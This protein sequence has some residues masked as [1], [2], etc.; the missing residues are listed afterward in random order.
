M[1]IIYL[2]QSKFP[3]ILSGFNL[4]E[5][6]NFVKGY[7]DPFFTF[8]LW[9]APIVGSIVAAISGIMYLLKDEDERDRHKFHKTLKKILTVTIIVESITVIFKIVGITTG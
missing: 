3:I 2:V 1:K 9:A 7:T 6:Q 8:L 4:G 5:A